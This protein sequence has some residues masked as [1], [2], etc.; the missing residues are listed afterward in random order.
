M[1]SDPKLRADP[2]TP[3]YWTSRSLARCRSTSTTDCG[4]GLD[5][6]G[7]RLSRLRFKAVQSAARC[8]AEG[9]QGRRCTN[10]GEAGWLGQFIRFAVAEV[11]E[12]R[13]GGETVLTKLSELMFI[14]VVRRYIETLPRRTAGWL[15][16]LR[17]PSVGKALTLIHAQA[18]TRL[19]RSKHS[20]N[21]A[22]VSRT[23]LA[24]RFA[25][26]VG[27]PPMQYVAKWR[28]QIASELSEQRQC[29]MAALPPQVGYEFRSFIQPRLQENDWR[30]AIGVAPRRAVEGS[31]D[32]DVVHGQ[33]DCGPEWQLLWSAVTR[34]E[35][36]RPPLPPDARTYTPDYGWLT[37]EILR[38][39]SE[40]VLDHFI[41][42][43]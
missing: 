21:N 2:P 22:G 12:K 6:S 29:N 23:V 17:D 33:R 4:R 20:R 16:G 25:E 37:I 10:G 18:G 24:E 9:D 39:L 13:A 40:V 14:D 35:R 27:I 32:C 36:R 11:A 3:T 5:Q 15:A 19:D 28:M 42:D 8:V 7:V 34:R 38:Y 26:L 30:G 41:R 1:S 43:L 31:A